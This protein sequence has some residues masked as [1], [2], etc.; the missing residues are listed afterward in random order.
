MT[1]THIAGLALIAGFGLAAPASATSLVLR[2]EPSAQI[3][4]LGQTA[5]IDIFADLDLGFSLTGFDFGLDVGGD[6]GVLGGSGSFDLNA[7]LF[8]TPGSSFGEVAGFALPLGAPSGSVFL[9]S[10]EY[11]GAAIGLATVSAADATG[12]L[13]AFTLLDG[14]TPVAFDFADADIDLSLASAT[15]EVIQIIPLPASAAMAAAGLL[16][17]AGVRRRRGLENPALT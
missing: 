11:T 5:T 13:P 3:I 8:D 14:F 16:A 2:F 4:G 17:V 6:P 9:G 15:I 12:A 10:I 7:G 1:R